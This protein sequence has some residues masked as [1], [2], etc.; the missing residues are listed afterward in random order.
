MNIYSWVFLLVMQVSPLS[1]P[2]ATVTGTWVNQSDQTQMDRLII[3][4]DIMFIFDDCQY[5]DCSWGGNYLE[6][7]DEHVYRSM[8]EHKGFDY[9]FYLVQTD[10]RN[11]KAVIEKRPPGKSGAVVD[12]Q[13]FTLE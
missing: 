11:L 13:F 7:V 10:E 4:G 1:T 2:Q 5:A 3:S 9:T 6:K 12:N 8:F